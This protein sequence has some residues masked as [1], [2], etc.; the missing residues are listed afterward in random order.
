MQKQYIE[1]NA[2]YLFYSCAVC[3]SSVWYVTNCILLHFYWINAEAEDR[4][5][6]LFSQQN[7]LFFIAISKQINKDKHNLV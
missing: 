3:V 6:F 4:I 7:L 2:I 1:K 5:A